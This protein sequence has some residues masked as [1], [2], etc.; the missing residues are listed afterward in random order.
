MSVRSPSVGHAVG[1]PADAM[2]EHVVAE[3]GHHGGQ[4]IGAMALCLAILVGFLLSAL[5][6][7]GRSLLPA[8]VALLPTWQLPVSLTR[9]RDPPDLYRLCII[10]C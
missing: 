10:R 4:D 1:P 5:L 3:G 2:T 9:D 6:L 7:H 8:L